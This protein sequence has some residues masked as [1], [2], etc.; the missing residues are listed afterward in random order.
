MS[1]L[2]VGLT[3]L[4]MAKSGDCIS[5]FTSLTQKMAQKKAA[6]HPGKNETKGGCKEGQTLTARWRF[7]VMVRNAGGS[8]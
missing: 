5:L 7:S 8:S 6:K 3:K 1:K 2:G 4:R